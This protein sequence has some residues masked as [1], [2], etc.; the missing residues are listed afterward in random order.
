MWSKKDGNVTKEKLIRKIDEEQFEY[1][2]KEEIKDKKFDFSSCVSGTTNE[3]SSSWQLLLPLCSAWHPITTHQH[4]SAS[5]FWILLH[6]FFAVPEFPLR[7]L[8]YSIASFGWLQEERK[9]KQLSYLRTPS[10]NLLLNQLDNL[11]TCHTEIQLHFCTI[12]IVCPVRQ[13]WLVLCNIYDFSSTM[14]T[15]TRCWLT[16]T[17][18]QNN[19]AAVQFQGIFWLLFRTSVLSWA[20]SLSKKIERPHTLCFAHLKHWGCVKFADRKNRW[21]TWLCFYSLFSGVCKN[22]V[23]SG[24]RPT[25]PQTCT[26]PTHRS[27]ESPV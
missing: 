20:F 12:Y 19:A 1:R 10:S 18:S 15:N 9:T 24:L 13:T 3:T 14:S 6:F 23:N 2:S 26:A 21:H 22:L 4:R 11:T 16:Y 8:R 5:P 7:W 17:A 25:W 27:P